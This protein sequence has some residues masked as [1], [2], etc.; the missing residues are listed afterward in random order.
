MRKL[1]VGVAALA[2]IACTPLAHADPGGQ[3]G[4]AKPFA[5]AGQPFIGN[6]RAHGEAVTVNGDGTGSET[7]ARGQVLFR[8]GSVQQSNTGQWDTAYGNVVSGFLERGSFVT[9]Q[10]VDGGNGMLF[11]AGGGDSGFPFCKMV[12][13]S[14]VNSADCGA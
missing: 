8:L 9:V 14:S 4:L 10:L 13:G 5:E 11:S 3:A 6:W 12:N 7:A 2:A 1:L